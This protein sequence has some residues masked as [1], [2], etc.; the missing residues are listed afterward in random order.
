VPI[1]CFKATAFKLHSGSRPSAAMISV[2]SRFKISIK[3]KYKTREARAASVIGALVKVIAALVVA[4]IVGEIV[5]VSAAFFVDIVVGAN[6]TG[7]RWPLTVE[8][9]IVVSFKGLVIGCIAGSILKKR[10]MQIDTQPAVWDGSL[11]SR[12]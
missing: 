9:V 12:R 8:N 2:W 7:G 4:P 11:L 6:A 1:D 5:A 3:H 10:G